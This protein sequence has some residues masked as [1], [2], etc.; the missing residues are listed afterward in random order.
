MATQLRW[1][2]LFG[3]MTGDATSYE[4]DDEFRNDA[5]DLLHI[6]KIRYAIGATGFVTDDDFLIVLTKSPT[7]ATAIVSNNSF[8][9]L[10]VRLALDGVDTGGPMSNNAN[11][12]DA[13]GRNQLTLKTG[14]SLFVNAR[15]DKAAQAVSY[16][17][18]IGYEYD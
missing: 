6:R 17:Y 15:S 7:S 4:M 12:G 8:F 9:Q 14:E 2:T 16:N 5:D 3:S 13:Y 18:E 1:E 10:P 11:G